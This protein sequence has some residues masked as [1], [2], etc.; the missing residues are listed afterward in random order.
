MLALVLSALAIRAAEAAQMDTPDAIDTIQVTATRTATPLLDTPASVSIVTGDRL[1]ARMATDLRTALSMLAGVEI[2]PGGD[3]GPAGSVPALWGLREFDA[4]LL[5]VDG[6]PWGGAFNP[7][8]TTLDLHNID[9]IE[10]LRGAAPVMY[11]ATSFVGVI[12]VIHLPAGEATNR[13]DLSAGGV[14]EN[15][16]D[17]AASVSRA[18]PQIGGWQ[19]SIG[20][21]IERRR[22]ADELARTER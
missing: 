20:A 11:G 16:G 14:P 10:V 9:R 19:Q 4:F 2:S 15:S 7:A 6:V 5:V 17:L 1:R 18:L 12:H 3:A 13:I 8:L 21:D 22:F